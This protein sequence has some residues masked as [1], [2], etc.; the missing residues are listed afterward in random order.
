MD[1]PFLS[2]SKGAAFGTVGRKGYFMITE[3]MASCSY[4]LVLSTMSFSRIL[5]GVLG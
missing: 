4:S 3:Y 5:H 2:R 1:I